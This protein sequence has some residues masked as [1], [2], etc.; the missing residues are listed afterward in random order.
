MRFPVILTSIGN[1]RGAEKVSRIKVL[2][3]LLGCGL[4]EAK[5]LVEEVPSVI[6]SD[7]SE[8]EARSLAARLGA[9]GM[10]A[11]VERL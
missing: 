1:A 8:A 3:E 4:V 5:Q 10:A 7:L 6:G 11:R 9:A 2:R